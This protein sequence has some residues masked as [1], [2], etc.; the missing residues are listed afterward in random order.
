MEIGGKARASLKEKD[1]QTKSPVDAMF[2]LKGLKE[3]EAAII[4]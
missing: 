4:F 2:S 3:V 1:E